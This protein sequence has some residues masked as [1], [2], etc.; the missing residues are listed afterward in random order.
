MV[1]EVRMG[2]MGTVGGSTAMGRAAVVTPAALLGVL[3]DPG[4][5]RR[6]GRPKSSGAVSGRA[7]SA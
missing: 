4:M 3:S 7:K 5:V 6:V 1:L 2:I